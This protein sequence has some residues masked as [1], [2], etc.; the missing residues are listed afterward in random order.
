MLLL[1]PNTLED[2]L[3]QLVLLANE[4]NS[5]KFGALSP[6]VNLSERLLSIIE[7]NIPSDISIAQDRLLLSLTR[8]RDYSNTIISKFENRQHLIE[9]LNATCFVPVYSDAF[10]KP[11]VIQGETFIDGACTNNLPTV[12]N[13]PTVTVSPFSGSAL[14]TPEDNN[15]FDWKMCISNQ[16]MNVNMQNVVRG[17][18]ALFPPSEEK[19]MDYYGAGFRD[20]MR[21]LLEK[22]WFE[23]EFGTEV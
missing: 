15:L 21:F 9:C 23:R 6:G 20:A 18:Q 7:Q 8:T 3:S 12:R 13:V 4:I 14:I 5:Y 1:S 17:A 22:R 10:S 19:L 11:P 16:I 2:G